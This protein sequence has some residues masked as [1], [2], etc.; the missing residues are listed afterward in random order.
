MPPRPRQLGGERL[1]PSTGDPDVRNEHLARYHFAEPLAHGKRVLDAGCGVGY[2]CE[3]LSRSADL[4]LGVDLSS[5]AVRQAARAAPGAAF[6]RGDCKS[7][8]VADASVDLVV[9]FEVIEHLEAWGRL[10]SEAA[11]VLAPGGAFVA[12]TPNRPYYQSTRT[13]PNPFHVH[14]FDHAEFR[15]ALANEFEHCRM[16]FQNH[17][18]A[19]SV[20]SGQTQAAR[21]FVE[22]V[23]FN[24]EDSHFFVA[25]CSSQP[26]E[27]LA[28]LAYIPDPGNVLRAREQHVRELKRWVTALESR[29]ATV[30]GR[31]SGELSRWPYRALRWLRLA[32]RLPSDWGG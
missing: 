4:T 28:D 1:V 19:I 14:E 23:G 9:A 25:V 13:E 7:L 16:F 17:V 22:P 3:I 6:A 8:P 10:V 15:A 12:S 2:G 21:G 26:L 27:G 31:M 30:E 5:D 29:H 24:P 11:R 32:P 20:S 18:S